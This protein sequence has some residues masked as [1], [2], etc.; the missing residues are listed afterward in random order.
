M[1]VILGIIKCLSIFW[2]SFYMPLALGAILVAVNANVEDAII[3]CL[4]FWS[5][6]TLIFLS[7][8]ICSLIWY[9]IT[10]QNSIN[11]VISI[12]LDY[13]KEISNAL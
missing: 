10:N 1:E 11:H 3:L 5:V 6:I 2:F 8:Y 13:F 9:I 4:W 12:L 7:L